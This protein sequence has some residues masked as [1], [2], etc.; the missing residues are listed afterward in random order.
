MYSG[1]G[2]AAG[3]GWDGIS[4]RGEGGG[5]GVELIEGV[6]CSE[7]TGEGVRLNWFSRSLNSKSV[8]GKCLV[9]SFSFRKLNQQ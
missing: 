8:V 2:A 5:E 7:V 3:S 9:G 1:S 6:G 4:S